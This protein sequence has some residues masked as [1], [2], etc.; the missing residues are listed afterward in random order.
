MHQVVADREAVLLDHAGGVHDLL[1]RRAMARDL[2]YRV[3]RRFRRLVQIAVERC[4]LRAHRECAQHLDVVCFGRFYDFFEKRDGRLGIVRRQPIYEKDRLDTVAPS[5]ILHLDPDLLARFPEGY[6]HLGYLQFKN[7]FT[8]KN[9][10]P[11]LRGVEV[12]KVYEE[13]GA[14]LAG[15]K[16]PGEAY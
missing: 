2:R 1:H 9:D 16:K 15:S 8:V 12:E 14:W 4:R 13:G 10:L 11:G 7:G 3:E 6:R 5:A